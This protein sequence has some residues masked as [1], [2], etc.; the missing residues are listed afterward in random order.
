MNIGLYFGSFNPVHVGHLIIANHVLNETTIEKIW[1]VVSPQ[2]PF[3]PS[4]GL[5][6]EYHRL[7]LVRLATEDDI[8]IKASDIEFNLPRPSYTA[9][10]LTYLAEKFPEHRFSIIM[11]SDSFQNLPKWKNYET[12][13]KNYP[14]YVYKRPG[15]EVTNGIG[16]DLHLLEAP[17]LELSATRIREYIREGRSARYMVPDKVLEEIEKGGYYK[18]QDQKK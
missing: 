2:N 4:Q 8:R 14:V 18:K 13:V 7:H 1:F 10:T 9:T 6:N 15:F 16:A 11:G 12:I 3:K 5:L 17:L